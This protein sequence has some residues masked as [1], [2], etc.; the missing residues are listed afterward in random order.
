MSPHRSPTHV[1]LS[2]VLLVV[3]A[4]ACF[5]VSDTIV[6][7]LTQHYP[8]PLLVFA[9]FGLQALA[10][11]LVLAPGM[12]WDLVRT[13]QPR[14]QILRGVMMI[15]S[16]LCFI[17]A[18]RWLPLADATAI[19]YTTPILVVLLS[20]GLLKERMTRSRW[21][22]V[23]VGFAGMLL[24]V[25][26]GASILHGAALLALCGAGFYALFQ[27]L[28][29]RLRGEDP[30]VTLFYPA[31]CATLVMTLTLPFLDYR[32]DMPWTHVAL[33]ATFGAI[34]TMGHFM[35]ILA[36]R[37]APASA[38]TPFTYAQLVWAV[39]LGWLAFGNFP[40]RFSLTG[41]AIIAASGL[42]LAWHERRRAQ[43]LVAT[44]EPTAVD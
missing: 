9:R 28:T 5:A 35:F 7:F 22:F 23:A 25:R 26:P 2:A 1:P 16:S 10:T 31:L 34:A 42:L 17:N 6:K 21:A 40:D 30:R 39:A 14:L 38:L 37:H 20:V 41:I 27:I 32:V 24:I 44:E 18:L 4:V 8:V 33:V 13:P 12:G 11:V 19:N 29:R 15:G 36:F 43:V 3:G